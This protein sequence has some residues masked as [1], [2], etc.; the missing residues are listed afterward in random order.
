MLENLLLAERHAISILIKDHD[1][2]KDLFES[3]REV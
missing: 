1:T 2:A 3:L